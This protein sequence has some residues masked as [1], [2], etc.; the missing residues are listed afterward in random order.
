M[1][2]I[3]LIRALAPGEE[4]EGPART[5]ARQAL[6]RSIERASTT[7]RATSTRPL[8]RRVLSLASAGTLAI[9]VIGGLI[10][11]FAGGASES[12][13][14]YG[15][16]LVRFAESTP[17]LLL[18]EP[19][20]RV[21]NVVQW[22]QSSGSMEFGPGPP[23]PARPH[24]SRSEI[25]DREAQLP[26]GLHVVKV[27]WAPWHRAGRWLKAYRA[28][29]FTAAAPV[30][31]TTAHIDPGARLSIPGAHGLHSMLAVWK[32]GDRVL[33]LSAW[34]PDLD[35]FRERLSW[36]AKV[37]AETWLDAMPTRVV[38]AA[39][40]G[41]EVGKMLRGIPVPAGFDASRIPDRRVTTNRYSVGKA[42]GGAVACEWFGRWFE[43]R[44]DQDL[45]AARE[46][47]Q[48]LLG[49]GSWPVFRRIA[50]EGAYPQLVVEFA[51][52]LP[53]G[54]WGNGRPLRQVINSGCTEIGFP[55]S[56]Q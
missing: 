12:P 27:G 13:P 39:E 33:S 43:A 50:N 20:W 2:E 30:L 15:A 53:S 35:A 18:E 37:D 56:H 6:E 28:H 10:A 55:L 45:R 41:A 29:G 25:I 22:Q 48:V 51:E 14:A 32:Q 1:D 4:P 46:A 16:E 24:P 3:A 17:L 9:A 21:R 42:V 49:S 40:Y 34:V 11:L 8:R 26:L 52:A 44:G 47:R 19:G 38:K 5:A 23:A 36:L 31:G 7:S 54:Q